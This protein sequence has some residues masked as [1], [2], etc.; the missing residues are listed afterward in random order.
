[1]KAILKTAQQINNIRQGGYYLNEI[2]LLIKKNAKIG[3]TLIELEE[4]ADNY[5]KKRNRIKGSFK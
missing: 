4:I 3:T 1:M 2:L 5:I